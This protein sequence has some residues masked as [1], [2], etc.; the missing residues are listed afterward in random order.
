MIAHSATVLLTAA[1]RG[2]NVGRLKKFHWGE[3]MSG[4]VFR[5]SRIA[6]RNAGAYALPFNLY[7]IVL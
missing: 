3:E 7:L 4:R 6:F 1:R 5:E 2:Y